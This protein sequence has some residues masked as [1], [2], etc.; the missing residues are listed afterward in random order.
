MHQMA[1]SAQGRGGCVI[2]KLDVESLLETFAFFFFFFF[3]LRATPEVY[4]SSQAKG[5]VGATAAILR[6]R[7]RN[8]GLELHL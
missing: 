5:L 1:V 7:H 2:E 3:L 4:G 6:H 8:A